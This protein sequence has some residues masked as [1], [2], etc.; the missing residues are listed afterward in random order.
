M[1]QLWALNSSP[2]INALWSSDQ[3]KM[4]RLRE[5]KNGFWRD[6]SCVCMRLMLKAWVSHQM[7]ESWQPC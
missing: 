5:E 4:N 6:I 2:V 7:R 1:L 3:Q